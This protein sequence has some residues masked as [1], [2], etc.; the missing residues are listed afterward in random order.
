MHCIASVRN[1]LIGV[2]AL[3][4]A[5]RQGCVFYRTSLRRAHYLINLP[6][7]PKIIRAFIDDRV[8]AD[9]KPATIKRYAATIARAHIAAGK[10]CAWG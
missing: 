2:G 7:D 9:K 8:K 1:N 10:P 5:V 4:D 6:A 3:R